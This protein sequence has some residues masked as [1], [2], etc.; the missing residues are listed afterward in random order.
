V[1]GQYFFKIDLEFLPLSGGT[2]S[3]NTY[4][5]SNLSANTYFSGATK[6]EDIIFNIASQATQ[7][8]GLFLPLSGGTGGPYKFIGNTTGE[9]FY[10]EN[11]IEPTTDNF[12]DLGKFSKRFRRIN[13]VDG[14]STVWT[15]TT[16]IYSPEINLGLD[17]NNQNRIITANNS[18][19]QDDKLFGGNY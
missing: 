6:L 7:G 1:A 12:V 3:G 4:F 8:S 13:T 15:A 16:A 9:T 11:A 19:I 18:I 5:S 10:I 14:I 17:S 2:V